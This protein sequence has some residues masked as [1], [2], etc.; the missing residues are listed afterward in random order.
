MG[1][2]HQR[3]HLAKYQFGHR[4]GVAAGLIG[5]PNLEFFGGF[6]IDPRGI[7]ADTSAGNNF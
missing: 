6:Q 2:A 7:D 4:N 1:V 3:D 5:H